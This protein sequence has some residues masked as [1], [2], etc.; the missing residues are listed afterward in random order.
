MLLL[1]V[2]LGLLI[3]SW[4]A[5]AF[6]KAEVQARLSRELTSD[7]D[8]YADL[9]AVSLREPLWQLPPLFAEPLIDKIMEDPKVTRIVVKR[10][11]EGQVFLERG[12]IK[13]T[14]VEPAARDIQMQGN[15]LGTVS[16]QVNED[17][18]TDAT[19]AAQQRFLWRTAYI[20]AAAIALI[21]ITLHLRLTRPVDKLVMQSEALA[22]GRLHETM[23]WHRNDELGRVGHS[24]ENT[25]RALAKLVG[26]LQTVN[27]D[28]RSE[29]EQRKKAETEIARHAEVLES[30]VA[31]R[32][33]ELSATNAT[34]SVTLSNL[35]Q[36]Q[37]DLVES[38]KLASLG[39]MVA[40]VAHELNTPI[41]N[42]L[43]IG[44]TIGERVRELQAQADAG[45]LK[46]STLTDF[47]TST[48]EAG[49]V[50]ER[51]L[52]RAAELVTSF[53]QVAESNSKE[54]LSTFELVHLTAGMASRFTT[55]SEDIAID[56][57]NRVP[58]GIFITG[59]PE[60]LRQVLGHLLNNTRVHAFDNRTEGQVIVQA[61]IAGNH[62]EITVSDNGTG[63][64]EDIQSRIFDPMFTTRM[65]RGGVGLGLS[66]V[67]NIV[68]RNMG[69]KVHVRNARP[70][71]ACF[72]LTLPLVAP[73]I[74]ADSDS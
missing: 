48:V 34:L 58:P 71:G 57:Q 5:F 44:S 33:Q 25:R 39:R 40:G 38:K 46:K 20:G 8:R 51:S 68:T 27:V 62:V 11:P 54:E 72:V 35:R 70:R 28:L 42:A 60:L 73:L 19:A 13:P 23:E 4:I 32:T 12:A 55:T 49:V 30:R 41:G 50:L 21:F 9:L 18:V 64:A 45:Q 1:A 17:G 56:F 74:P 69:G 43:T 14:S 16:V 3:P 37:H 10:M 36:T 66:V 2:L 67:H 31:E 24:L 22:D 52:A 59:Y 61:Y 7:R 29:N 65:G 6:E 15:T 63:I 47:L 53:K 26:E